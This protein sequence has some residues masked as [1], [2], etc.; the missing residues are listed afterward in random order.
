M[1]S[2]SYSYIIPY[3][4]CIMRR[5][6]MSLSINDIN[7]IANNILR[8]EELGDVNIF[9][10]NSSHTYLSNFEKSSN[11]IYINKRLLSMTALTY[12][13]KEEIVLIIRMYLEIAHKNNCQVSTYN[14]YYKLLQLKKNNEIS[15]NELMEYN[16][17]LKDIETLAWDYCENRIKAE[18]PDYIDDCRRLHTVSLDNI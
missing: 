11:T 3:T 17:I 1:K 6:I 5:F 16:K 7:A 9:V 8:R 18:Y 12:G 2:S 13:I 10:D 4:V 14:R 15:T